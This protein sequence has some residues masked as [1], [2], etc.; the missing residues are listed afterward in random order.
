MNQDYIE[1]F[2]LRGSQ[3]DQ[4][5]KLYPNGRNQEF[6]QALGNV[7]LSEGMRVVDVPSGGEY[8]RRF[9]PS[10]VIYL[11][12]EPCDTF[13]REGNKNSDS[14]L[15]L[16]FESEE[17]DVLFSIAGIHHLE[18]KTELFREFFR[19]LK[20]GG[21]AVLS[22]VRKGSKVATFLDGYVGTCNSTGHQ[23]IFLDERTVGELEQCG[24][25]V[26]SESLVPFDWIFEDENA[27]GFFCNTL[28]DITKA[29]VEDTIEAIK[30]QLGI[31][32]LP[33]GRVGMNWELLTIVIRKSFTGD[34]K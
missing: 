27:M 9:L 12:H 31:K 5:M 17:A 28:F 26:V 23:G 33:D 29:S 14:L 15:P 8:L 1:L 11:P 22:D 32:K 21:T 16:P 10:E 13:Y 7:S 2:S 4:A 25:S 34:Q 19:V 24:F 6:L 30:N 18:D 3:Y 20:Q